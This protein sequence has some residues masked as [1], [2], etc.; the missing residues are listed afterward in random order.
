VSQDFPKTVFEIEKNKYLNNKEKY[1]QYNF[2]GE[3]FYMSE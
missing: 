2:M 3:V 1:A